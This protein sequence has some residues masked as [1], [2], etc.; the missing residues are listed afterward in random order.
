MYCWMHVSCAVSTS[1]KHEREGMRKCA[2]KQQETRYEDAKKNKYV[3][4]NTSSLGYAQ[5]YFAGHKVHIF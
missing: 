5:F 1:E 3:R 2:E 4:H